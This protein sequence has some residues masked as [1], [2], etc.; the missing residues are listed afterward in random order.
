MSRICL[1]CIIQF[2][3]VKKILF[4]FGENNIK[5][6]LIFISFLNLKK[7]LVMRKL[8]FLFFYIVNIALLSTYLIQFTTKNLTSFKVIDRSIF[9]F[10]C[11]SIKYAIKLY[12]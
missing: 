4:L 11:I 12:T 5:L 9:L 2:R 8:I 10:I 6:P 3:A 1:K 7:K